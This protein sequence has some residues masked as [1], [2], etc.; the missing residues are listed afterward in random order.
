MPTPRQLRN[1][2]IVEVAID[3]RVKSRPAFQA[4]SFT[5]VHAA[6][7]DRFPHERR[8]S[9]SQTVW[10][11]SDEG[12]TGPVTTERGLIGYHFLTA[13]ERTIAQFR[14][15]GFTYNRLA[16]YTRWED[17]FPE[18]I[19]LFERYT[20]IAQHEGIIRLAVR[21]INRIDL[22]SQPFDLDRFF[23]AAPKVPE[24]L[25]QTIA[26][27]LSRITIAGGGLATAVH[28]TQ[29]LEYRDSRAAVILDIDA[30][31]DFSVPPDDRAAIV[32]TFDS[33]RVFKNEVFFRHITDE[34]TQYLERESQ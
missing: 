6:I 19:E 4:A 29:A 12:S 28:V 5:E 30:F 16:P 22:P 14:I 23:T 20:A 32:Q 18:A 25:P 17:V 24:G 11:L 21:N 10:K 3:F 31:R 26:G 9:L 7:R 27:F 1:P 33:L 13:D 8:Q 34:C 15:D 2:P